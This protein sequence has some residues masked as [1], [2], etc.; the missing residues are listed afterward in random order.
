MRALSFRARSTAV[1]PLTQGML[2]ASASLSA[3]RR[4]ET[5]T[6]VLCGMLSGMAPDLDA[7]IRSADDPLLYLEYHRHFTHSL[8][9]IPI[10]GL[11]C[12]AMLRPLLARRIPFL[13]VLL[14]C[15]LGFATHG[16]L[17]ACTTYGTLLLWP[18]SS[19]R[20]AWHT[21]SIID[22]L[23]TGPLLVLVLAGCARKRR[24]LG[25]AALAWALLYLGFGA[26][27]RARVEA[28]GHELAQSRGHQPLRLAAKP[29][30]ANLLVWKLVYETADGF[31]VDG[32]RAGREVTIY[33]GGRIPALDV[34]RDL[35]WLPSDSQQ[36]RDIERF[37]W[38]SNNYLAL[39]PDRA[40]FII[41]IRYSFVPNEIEALWGISLAVDAKPQAHVTFLWDRRL[42]AENKARFV[43]MLRGTTLP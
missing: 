2:G 26:A 7:L 11:V 30:F 38:F 17:D 39:D 25:L 19:M 5:V 9:F 1:D 8:V 16:L 15:T 23:F 20:I 43:A 29:G 41:D 18:F 33:P 28:I 4:R 12:A 31:H 21:V 35:P 37:R 40:N 24:A 42:T 14:Y 27:Q 3:S 22:P 36:A 10:G 13:R 32:V 34:A 6:A